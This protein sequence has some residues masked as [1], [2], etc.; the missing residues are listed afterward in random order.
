MVAQVNLWGTM[1]GAVLW[2]ADKNLGIF[3]FSPDF[4]KK[5]WDIAPLTMP[6]EEALSGKTIFSFPSLHKD[7]YKGL[8]G[9]LADSLP[10][11]FG[12]KL[13]DAWL[14]GQGRNPNDFNPVERL[15]YTG[16][17]GMGALEFEPV[18]STFEEKSTQV[19][20]EKLLTLTK[21]TLSGRFSSGAHTKAAKE[22][23]LKEIIKAGT[24]AGGARAKAVIAYNK[25][26]GD[27]R[28]GHMDKL[29]GYD[30]WIIKFDG[31]DNKLLGDPKGYGRIE[32]AY[33]QMALEC[34]ISMTECKLL[35]EEEN[36]RAH[37]ISKRFD[38]Q[39]NEKIHMQTLCAIAHY[40]YNDPLSHSYEQ[41]F[42]VMRLLRLPYADAEQLYTRMVFNVIA[43]NQNDHTKNIAFLMDQH[44]QWKLSPAYDVTYAY[45][46]LNKWMKAHQMSINGKRDGIERKDLLT[47]ANQMSIRRPKEIIEQTIDTVSNWKKYAKEAGLKK[48][49]IKA[50]A[51]THLLGI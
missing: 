27:M 10:D 31:V 45:N 8:P 6:L 41:A 26:T 49:Q 38:R 19:E 7:T 30:Y 28:C 40:N 36:V 35:E 20:V 2:D 25:T 51:A 13:L 17:R 18:T 3:E 32:Y 15:G 11:A 5:A 42:Q 9:L 22:E 44:G 24:S 43:R 14:A 34:G 46:P 37:F 23:G 50:I 29:D 12:N 21:E 33:H 39:A 48:K 1:V 16:K 4:L 47:V